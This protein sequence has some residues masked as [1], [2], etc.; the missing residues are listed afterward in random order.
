MERRTFLANLALGSAAVAAL[1][2]RTA[3][4]DSSDGAPLA[5]KRKR[6]DS[7]PYGL[8]PPSSLPMPFAVAGFRRGKRRRVACSA[9]TK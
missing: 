6:P 1:P 8:G 7:P 4:A 5:W 2:L 3:S 9:F